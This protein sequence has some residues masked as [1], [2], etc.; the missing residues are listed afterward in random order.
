LANGLLRL[1]I[2]RSPD[3][4]LVIDDP[5]VSNQHAVIHW[6]GTAGVLIELGSSNGT[7]V[8]NQRVQGERPLVS[9]DQLA[10]GR[11]HFVYHLAASLHERLKRAA[12]SR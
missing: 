5:A 8:N 10:F 7:F 11:S 6:N 3:C 2:G 9:G 12:A 4:E 1:V